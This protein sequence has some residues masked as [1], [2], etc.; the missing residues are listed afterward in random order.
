MRFDRPLQSWDG[1]GFNYVEACQTRDYG[2]SP[3]DYG[4]LSDLPEATRRRVCE[5][6]FGQDGL[7]PGLLKMFLDPWQQRA[8]NAAHDHETSTHWMRWFAREGSRL[9]AAR[10]EELAVLTT[11]Y[12]PPG[13]MT[14]Q[15]ILRGR[16]LAPGAMDALVDYVASWARFLREQEG[17][18]LRAV[19]LHNEGEDWSRWP[20]DGSGPG[21]EGHDYNLHWPPAQVAAGLVAMRRRLDAMGLRDVLVGPGETT[22]WRR[23]HEWGY[24]DA[25]AEDPDALAA[26]GLITSHG[27]FA[28]GLGRWSADY[29]SAGIDL[30][31]AK[32]PG[33]HA[34]TTSTG[35]GTQHLSLLWEIQQSLMSAKING[36]IPWAGIQREGRWT[37]G[38]PNP[39]AAMHVTEA[40]ELRVNREYHVY[41]HACRAG[42]PGSRVATVSSN[43]SEVV[44]FAFSA[45]ESA[46]GAGDALVLANLSDT[47]KPLRLNVG[48]VAGGSARVFDAAMTTETEDWVALPQVALPATL[49]LPPKAAVSLVALR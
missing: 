1:F 3:Q 18:R 7:R 23:F 41:R 40:G 45:P 49:L 36:F 44:L 29:R 38:D 22:N 25:I 30:L 34:W 43:D 31:R 48:D 46:S 2:R 33:L 15:G 16:D 39:H 21:D 11:L 6:V 20:D 10:G 4:G 35:W 14:V 28:P 17:L 8:A 12:G 47:A 32:K 26:L 9:T 37:G 24:A 27:F 5:L 42:R 19:A 13:W